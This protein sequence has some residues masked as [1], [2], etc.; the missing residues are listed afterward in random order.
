MSYIET[1][2]CISLL[3]ESKCADF[4]VTGC[5]SGQGMTLACNSL[6]GVLCGYP[7]KDAERKR[8]NAKQLKQINSLCKKSLSEILPELERDIVKKAL[9]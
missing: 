3:L 6:P 8:H 7:K 9:S 5:S 2:L 1:A 4:I